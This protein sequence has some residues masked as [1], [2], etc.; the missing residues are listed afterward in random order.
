MKAKSLGRSG[1]RV[2]RLGLGTMSWGSD[3]DEYVADEQLGAYLEAGGTFIDTAPIYGDGQCEP[4]VG[5][6]LERRSVRE[7]IVLA[8]KAGLGYRA[9]EVVRDSS[10]R[11]LIDQLNQSLRD[12]RTDH[13][14]VWQVHRYDSSTPFDEVMSALEYAVSSGKVHY[15][16]ISNYN[17]WQTALAEQTL[18]HLSGG[19]VFLASNQVEYSLLH[20]RPQA[21]VIE[22][23]SHLRLGVL[24]WSPLGRGVLTGKYRSGI[25]ADSRAADPRWEAFVAGY[26]TDHSSR[27]VE[28]VA[29][30]AEGLGATP[31]QVALAWVRDIP[32]V[33][34][35]IIGARTL[36]QLR[37][38]LASEEL[39]LPQEIHD[40][41]SDVSIG[42]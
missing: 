37:E 9:G 20:A 25:P 10:R 34:S 40:A 36:S 42:A 39:V 14:D 4:L 32:V 17:G 31:G 2:S 26:L 18:S 7:S 1:L 28:A 16:G 38:S 12:L 22:A 8:G 27:V 5:A 41:L 11:T 6:L 29:R 35:A 13:L 23:A 24:A 30:A 33:S 15:V 21:E 19:R 3:I